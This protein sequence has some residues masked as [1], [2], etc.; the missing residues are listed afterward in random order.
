V[1]EGFEWPW[2]EGRPARFLLQLRCADLAE[3]VDHTLLPRDGMLWFFL[4]GTWR[5][6]RACVIHR[7]DVGALSTLPPP[8][9]HRLATPILPACGVQGELVLTLPEVWTEEWESL[10]CAA[11][12]ERASWRLLLQIDSDDDLGLRWGDCGVL[13]FG[14]RA[15]D[16]RA[17]RFERAAV[18]WQTT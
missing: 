3:Y 4:G 17:E 13:Y 15:D 14:M 9:D 10:W 11:D 1:P 5:D 18:T 12:R 2:V 16:L 8:A 6:H 7:R